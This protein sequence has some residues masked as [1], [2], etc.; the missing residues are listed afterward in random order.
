MTHKQWINR[1]EVLNNYP[2]LTH[3]LTT[4]K[5]IV[6]IYGEIWQVKSGTYKCRIW[7]TRAARV[8]SLTG[9]T[10]KAGDEAIIAFSDS[11]FDFYISLIKAPKLAQSQI[12][13]VMQYIKE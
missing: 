11:E 12:S 3:R 6:G 10:Y 7:N 4:E 5:A 13:C 1:K 2:C 8:K 9:K